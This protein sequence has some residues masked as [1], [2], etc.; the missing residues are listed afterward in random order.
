MVFL[1]VAILGF[2]PGITTDYDMLRWAGHHSGAK[3][4][5]IFEVPALHNVVHPI[6]GVA[7]LPMALAVRSARSYLIG[8]GVIYAVLWLY[9]L[10]I[11]RESQV[12]FVP[13]NTADNWLHFALTVGMIA[14]GALLSRRAVAS[15]SETAVPHTTR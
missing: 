3:L 9:G 15:T 14:L 2:I 6:F 5:G 8:G 4:F 12:N 13:A 1:L 7:G 11:D 10:V